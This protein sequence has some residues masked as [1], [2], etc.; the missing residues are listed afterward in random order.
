MNQEVNK[1]MAAL[2]IQ[3]VLVDIGASGV[4][5]KVWE[6]IA[7]HSIYLGFDP[8]RRELHDGGAGQYARS[9]IVNKAV[10]SVHDQ[11]QVRF[12]LTKSPY[13]SSTLP[14]D[15]ASLASYLFSDLFTVE[16]E[17]SVPTVTLSKMISRLGLPSVDWLK[18][19]SQ[20]TD[21]RL[22]RA[23]PGQ[24]HELLRASRMGTIRARSQD[25]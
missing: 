10:T 3:P 20:G 11:T 23:R 14:P 4:P 13:C 24:L 9:I 1:V 18:T 21:L 5:P 16:R 25:H 12:Y 8:D 22:S 19:D 7:R 6:P 17:V 15:A 2:N